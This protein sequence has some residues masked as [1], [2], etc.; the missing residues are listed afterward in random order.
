MLTAAV[1]TRN[2]TKTFATVLFICMQSHQ[3]R[4]YCSVHRHAISPRRLLQ[5]CSQA[6]NLTKTFATV[7][8]TG[9]QSHQ[10]VCCCSVHRHV[11]SPRRLLL[12]CSQARNLTKTFAAVLFTGTQSHQDVCCLCSFAMSPGHFPEPFF[13]SVNVFSCNDSLICGFFF[14]IDPEILKNY[15][16][17]S[18]LSFISK[19]LERI[20]LFNSLTIFRQTATH[21][22]QH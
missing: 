10:D 11:I 18:N 12:F 15:K 16:P 21:W 14:F 19:V 6:R 17:V 8:F 7:L 13:V 9:T 1:P 3:E 5:F 22:S 4:C 20:V 2:L